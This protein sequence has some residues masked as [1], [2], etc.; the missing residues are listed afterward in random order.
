MILKIHRSFGVTTIFV[1]HDQEEAVLLADRIALMFDG[2]LQ[3][4]SYPQEFYEKPASKRIAAFFG[5]TNFLSGVKE[6]TIVKTDIGDFV[7]SEYD[8]PDGN[9]TMIIRPESI[10]LGNTGENS[11]RVPVNRRIYMGTYTRYIISVNGSEWNVIG[12]PHYTEE[13]DEGRI[14]DFS[15]PKEKIWILGE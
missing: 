14:T 5:N 10:I 12:D 8:I 15:L 2:E 13:Y 6:G 9:V 4:F 7:I 1:T 11:F 3:Q